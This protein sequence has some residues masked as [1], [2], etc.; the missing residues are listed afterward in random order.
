MRR[1]VAAGVLGLL[2]AAGVGA[3]PLA[4]PEA[5]ARGRELLMLGDP[6]GAADAFH[7]ALRGGDVAR[8]TVRVGVYC[9]IANLERQV[10]ASGSPPELFVLRRAVAGR[11]C[12]ALFWGL[13]PSR[14]EARAA[15]PTIPAAL[16]ASGQSPVTVSSVLP[17]GEPPPSRVA[18][19]PPPAPPPEPIAPAP[20]AP[21]EAEPEPAA[22]PAPPVAEPTAPP[23]VEPAPSA[24]PPAVQEERAPTGASEDSVR[25]PA[26][27]V[28]VAWSGLW[29]DAFSRDGGDGLYELGWL[30][31]LCANMNRSLGIV[32]EASG[33][34]TSDDI[35]DTVGAPLAV[36]RD[37][38][39]VHAGVRYT[40]ARGGRAMPYLQALGGWTRSGFEV[41]GGREVEDAFSIQPGVGLHLQLSRSAGLALGADYRLVLGREENR[42]EV[43]FHAGLVFAV[44]DR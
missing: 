5:L 27:E 4:S 40:L 21:P 44:G 23:P 2:A 33:H 30:V 17:P 15:V 41:A 8:H 18:T 34:Y 31:S 32:G 22:E 36:D 3:Q 43:R 24:A 6:L 26:M 38:L 19:T 9:D 11:P 10:R 39:G 25:I 20:A 29:D 1:R 16:R 14:A 42:N 35:L 7:E 12:L 37:L 28:T 13:F